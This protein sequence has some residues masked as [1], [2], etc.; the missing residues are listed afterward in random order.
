MTRKEAFIDDGQ[1][2][3]NEQVWQRKKISSTFWASCTSRITEG[4]NND[5]PATVSPQNYFKKQLQPLKQLLLTE[6]SNWNPSTHS[7]G[8]NVGLDVAVLREVQ[9]MYINQLR[10]TLKNYKSPFMEE[11]CKKTYRK[12][13]TTYRRWDKFLPE[14]KQVLARVSLFFYSLN[15]SFSVPFLD[16]RLLPTTP[17]K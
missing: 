1:H 13:F 15:S 5:N 10:D 8:I 16:I 12:L 4:D 14:E 3:Y 7:D 9:N 6:K 2:G 11:R 17:E